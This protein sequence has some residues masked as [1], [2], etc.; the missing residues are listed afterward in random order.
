MDES[1]T[2]ADDSHLTYV[3]LDNETRVIMKR[4]SRGE[5]Q[6][7]GVLVK[8]IRALSKMKSN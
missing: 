2:Q 1:R 8:F 4:A 6:E 7:G 3:L 5:I